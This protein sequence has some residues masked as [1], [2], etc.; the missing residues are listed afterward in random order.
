MTLPEFESVLKQ[1]F[2]LNGLSLQ[3]Q[4]NQYK[5][6]FDAMN[7][8]LEK[9]KVRNRIEKQDRTSKNMNFNKSR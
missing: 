3:L 1:M 4:E 7:I 2:T 6:M 5:Q 8:I 9:N